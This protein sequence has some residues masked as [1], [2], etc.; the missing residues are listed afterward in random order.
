MATIPIIRFVVP[1]VP[2]PQPRP[3]AVMA[4]K[5][6]RVHELTHVKQADGTR[7]PHAIVAF[8]ATCRMAA[9]AAYSGPPA[10]EAL[11]L[12]ATFVLPRPKSK[13]WKTRP[14]ERYPHV[15]K[16]DLDN[17]VKGLKDALS[18]ILWRDDG[19]VCG[20][21]L[22]KFVAAGDEQP[23]VVVMISPAAKEGA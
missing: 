16:P 13:I 4:G 5:H 6:A 20:E 22:W 10:D 3:R 15:G 17:L 1:A 8:K 23:H 7:R 21:S 9:Q 12:H 11:A 18:G 14:M 19:L 2:V